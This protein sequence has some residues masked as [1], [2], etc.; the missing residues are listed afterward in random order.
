MN[1]L[2]ILLADDHG[3]FRQGLRKVLEEMPEIEIIGE[4]E[5]GLDLMNLLGKVAP[6]M[7]LLDLSMPNLVG[8]EAISKIKMHHPAVKILVVTMHED[9]EYLSRAIMAGADG[10]FLKREVVKELFS[11]IERVRSGKVYVSPS[12][13][14]EFTK[15]WERIREGF[16]KSLLTN[17]EKEVLS[18]I[19]QG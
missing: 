7:I 16:R 2:R 10:Y 13:S 18:L 14:E 9:M 17:R 1:T 8:I 3:L 19:G 11:A 5:D 15:D 12:L 6:D 4:A